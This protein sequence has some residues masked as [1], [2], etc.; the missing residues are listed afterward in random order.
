MAAVEGL[1]FN[2]II[3]AVFGAICAAIAHDR[4]R[5]AIGWFFIGAFTNCIGLIL[6]LVLPNVKEQEAQ[7]SRMRNENR[8]LRERLR[9]ERMVSDER[10]AE[11][12]Q[13]LQVHDEALGVDT[14]RASANIDAGEAPEPR[15]AAPRAP[16]LDDG[17]DWYYLEGQNRVGPVTIVD[18]HRLWSERR[19]SNET[20][21]WS[22]AMAD[23]AALNTVDSLRKAFDV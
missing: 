6:L 16:I 14:S 23:W 20:L 21:V 10:H 22:A 18:M 8:R 9:K 5:S 13:R 7:Q 11:T 12:E 1:L 4:G 17:I 15:A 2:F 19:I 3:M